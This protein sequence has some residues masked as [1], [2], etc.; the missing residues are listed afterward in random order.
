MVS[1]Q[2]DS[3]QIQVDIAGIKKDVSYLASQVAKQDMKQDTIL[4]RVNQLS[5]VSESDYVN[6][7]KELEKRLK[8]IEDRQQEAGPVVRF[9]TALTGRLSQV[10]IGVI[11]VVLIAALASQATKFLGGA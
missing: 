10:I 6:D 7:R 4:E 2:Q 11:I 8:A 5:F 1:R 3:T 9:Y